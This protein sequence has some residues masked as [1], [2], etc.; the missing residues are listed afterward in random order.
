MNPLSV[1]S[2]ANMF[3][4]SLGCLFVLFRVS[5]AVQKVLNLIKSHWFFFVLI[6]ITLG[7]GSEKILL[8]FISESV[9]PSF[10]SRVLCY[11]VFYLG[12]SS[13]LHLLLCV[14]LGSVLISFFSMWLSR[15]HGII[16]WRYSLFSIVCSR[17]YCHRLVDCR[18]VGLILGFLS[19]STDVHFCL[20]ASTI[21]FWCLVE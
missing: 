20:C 10:P 7:G 3:S 19:C 8:W 15:F 1:S 4:H 9:W 14:V 11:L 21:W 5:F 2:F 16:Y 13:I 6:D 18:R 17:F 12:L